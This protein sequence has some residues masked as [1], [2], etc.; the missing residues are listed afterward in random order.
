MAS[1]AGQLGILVIHGVGSQRSGYSG[2]MIREISGR[3]GEHASMVVWEEIVWTDILAP[4]EHDLLSWMK[5]AKD[6]EGSPIEL[7]WSKIRKFLLHNVGDALAYH[8][9]QDP[10]SAYA[11]IH[12]VVDQ[13][14]QA[15]RGSLDDLA[16][17]I[18]VIGHS[19]GAHIMSDYIWDRQHGVGSLQPIP[20]LVSMI[21][22]GCNIPLFSLSFDIAEPIDLPGKGITKPKWRAAARWLNYLDEDDVL[23]WPLKA[24]YQRNL[25]QLTSAQKR[26][27]SK[28]EDREINVGGFLTSWNPAAHEKYWTDNDF[29]RPVAAYL[30][31]LC[32]LV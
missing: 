18:V 13:K 29:T 8:R 1:M 16:A 14:L 19:L 17:P 25:S 11:Q 10:D 21:T 9:N 15:L 4:R 23:G 12:S 3:L 27:V 20:T 22:F 31:Q 28:I 6:A 32:E 30:K 26:T 5:K 24:L 2:E 7:D